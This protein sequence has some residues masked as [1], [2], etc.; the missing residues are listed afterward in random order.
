MKYLLMIYDAEGQSPQ[1]GTPEFEQMMAGYKAFSE[2]VQSKG[3]MLGG[4]PLEPVATATSVRMRD[5]NV[6]LTDGPFAETK[7]QL[8]GFYLLECESLD[9]ALA[10]AEEIPSAAW[11]TV[12]VRPVADFG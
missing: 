10:Y 7:E 5:G 3:I 8:G 4:E 6:Q 1:Y 11:G 12:E 2:K 9:E